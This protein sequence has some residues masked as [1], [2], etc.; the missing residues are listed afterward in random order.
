MPESGTTITSR[1]PEK[2]RALAEAAAAESGESLS[3]FTRKAVRERAA[4]VLMEDGA[5]SQERPD[6]ASREKNRTPVPA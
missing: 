6:K 3:L 2:T 1:V 4:R 5:V